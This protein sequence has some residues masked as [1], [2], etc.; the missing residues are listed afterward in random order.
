MQ[1]PDIGVQRKFHARA[2]EHRRN[3]VRLDGQNPI[4]NGPFLSVAMKQIVADRN[5]LQGYNVARVKL[6]RALEVTQCLFLFALAA[7]NVSVQLEYLRIIWQALA[8]NTQFSESAPI[9]QVSLIKIRRTRQMCF[10][11]IRTQTK[12]S[13]NSCFRQCQAGRCM[14]EAKE[15]KEVM[16]AG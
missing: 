2:R 10:T 16:G 14:I 5:L 7:L 12:C 9:I 11:C 1:R 15:V 13:L 6:Y 3:V 4:Q 8:S